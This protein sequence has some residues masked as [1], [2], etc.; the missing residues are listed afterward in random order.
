MANRRVRLFSRRSVEVQPL[1][2]LNEYIFHSGY[3]KDNM[4]TV[5]TL[6][7]D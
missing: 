3:S 7:G 2:V 1:Y 6:F 5:K 4:T